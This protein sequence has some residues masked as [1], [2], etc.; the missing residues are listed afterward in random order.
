METNKLKLG[1]RN[2]RLIN[3]LVQN[4]LKNVKIR[5]NKFKN[6]YIYILRL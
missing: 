5:Y 2:E 3:L 4:C 1:Q 6:I